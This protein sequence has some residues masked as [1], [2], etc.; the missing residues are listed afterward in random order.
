VYVHEPAS[1]RP[2]GN[3]QPI[4]EKAVQDG[5]RK[6]HLDRSLTHAVAGSVTPLNDRSRCVDIASALADITFVQGGCLYVFEE[7]VSVMSA[8]LARVVDI[9][10][11]R[12]KREESAAR[13]AATSAAPM[14]T[15]AVWM[16]SCW[17]WVMVPAYPAT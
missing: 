14:R 16:T 6:N 17:V 7:E 10:E 1:V 9:Q 2:H 15:M 5:A 8:Q 13:P 3:P 12:R 11:F 4:S